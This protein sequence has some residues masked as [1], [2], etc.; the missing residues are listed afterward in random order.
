MRRAVIRVRDKM[1]ANYRY[2]LTEPEGQNFDAEFRPRLT[3]RSCSVSGSLA[4]VI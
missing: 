3:P 2:E 4:A 1:Q